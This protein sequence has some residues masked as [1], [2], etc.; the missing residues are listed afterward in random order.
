MIAGVLEGDQ[1]VRKPRACFHAECRKVVIVEDVFDVFLNYICFGSDARTRSTEGWVGTAMTQGSM[2]AASAK[3]L[4]E[5]LDVKFQNFI[6]ELDL[7]YS[8]ED[9]SVAVVED[10]VR[11]L[12]LAY[13]NPATSPEVEHHLRELQGM[14][15]DFCDW[16]RFNSIDRQ[17]MLLGQF[18]SLL[19]NLGLGTERCIDVPLFALDARMMELELRGRSPRFVSRLECVLRD[20]KGWRILCDGRL[21]SEFFE[22]TF[23]RKA[24]F[25][26][27]ADYVPADVMPCRHAPHCDDFDRRYVVGTCVGGKRRKREVAPWKQT[28]YKFLF[29]AEAHCLQCM[30]F[31]AA[32]PGFDLHCRSCD[33]NAREWAE[34]NKCLRMSEELD[35]W[36]SD[37]GL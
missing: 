7:L 12:V 34:S 4:E 11:E 5:F 32:Q 19:W 36:L 14:L 22:G 17:K 27:G 18:R 10:A 30:Q 33:L 35:Q 6:D 25:V 20:F 31:Y 3:K 24:T 9:V 26:D 1:R 8:A 15:L 23:W 13:P 29:A 21:P 16:K 2:N 28:E 37:R